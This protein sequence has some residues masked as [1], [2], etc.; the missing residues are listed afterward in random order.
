M[1]SFDVHLLSALLGIIWVD[2]VLAGDNAVV[3]GMAAAGLPREQRMRAI[4]IGIL[5]ATVLR[6]AFATVAKSLLLYIGLVIAGGIL[7]LWVCWKL[8]RELRQQRQEESAV[9]EL[10]AEVGCVL[11]TADFDGS[12]LT[13]RPVNNPATKKTLS[14]AAVQIVVADVSMSL[15]NVIAVAGMAH[16]HPWWVLGAGLVLSIGFMGAAATFIA[17]LLK[18]YHWIA[19]VGLIII[20]YVAGKMIYDGT[21]RIIECLELGR[22]LVDCFVGNSTDLLQT[23]GQ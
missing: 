8:W 14:Q 15:D 6:I 7:L 1:F 5:G 20:L 21:I 10:E 11:P 9:D 13:G 18:R 4:L 19:Y 23:G 22:T 16:G 2:L 17:G 3:V 12:L